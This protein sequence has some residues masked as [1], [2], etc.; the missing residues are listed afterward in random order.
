[1]TKYIDTTK[2]EVEKPEPKKTVFTYHLSPK[3]GWVVAQMAPDAFLEVK[4]IHNCQRDGDMF[5][6]LSRNGSVLIF[7]G[8]KGDEFN[9]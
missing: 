6:A 3:C 8:I 7:K 4:F 1:M 2:Q 5:S 9:G